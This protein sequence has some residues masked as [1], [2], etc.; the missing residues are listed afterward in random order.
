MRSA[1]GVAPTGIAPPSCTSPALVQAKI[2][3]ISD[4]NISIPDRLRKAL[5]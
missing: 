4:T 1:P 2:S 5:V 3:G